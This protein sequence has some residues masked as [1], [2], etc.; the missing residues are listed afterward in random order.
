[1][2]GT[3]ATPLDHHH[4]VALQHRVHDARRLLLEA[5]DRLVDLDAAVQRGDAHL[6]AAAHRQAT[7]LAAASQQLVDDLGSLVKADVVVDL[8]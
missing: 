4:R 7:S 1:M 3:T 8:T 5:A 2:D 6:T